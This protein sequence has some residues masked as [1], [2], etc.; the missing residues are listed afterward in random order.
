[1]QH[2]IKLEN[3]TKVHFIGVGGISMNGLAQILARDGYVVSGSDKQASEVTRILQK[4][5]IDIKVP[6]AA[7]NI[8]P[9]YD[10][11]VFTDAIQPDNPEYA[12]AVELGLPMMGRASLLKIIT[13]GY[14]RTVC[15]AGSHGK[16]TTTALL[17]SVAQAAGLDP[18]VHVGGHVAGALNNR[19]GESPFFLLEACEYKNNFLQWHPYIGVILNIDADHNDF[20]GGGIDGLIDSFAQFARNIHPEGALII[21]AQTQGFDRI[22]AGL[23]CRVISFGLYENPTGVHLYPRDVSFSDGGQPYFSAVK[24]DEV[25]ASVDLALVGEHNIANALACFAVAEALALAPQAVKRGLEAAPGVK[26]RYEYK[27]EFNSVPII[28]DYA[29]HPTEVRACLAASRKKH[30]GRIVCVFQPH[31]YSRTRDLMEEFANSFGD[32][33]KVLLLPIYAA[34]EVHD[35]TVS[36]EQLCDLMRRRNCDVECF[37]DFYTAEQWL[38]LHLV[39]GDL[40]LTVGAGNVHL[41]AETLL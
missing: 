5:G 12:R 36:S 18:T 15:V 27:G 41:I 35:P 2:K 19:V 26:R 25:L 31:L 17:A 6:N 34:R 40:L 14:E 16:T 21:N 20:Y 22:V 28:D 11:I 3:V 29:H 7:D 4:A 9:E 23:A 39:A 32:A 33:D 37:D 10:L 38:R 30:S 24:G 1:M 13:Q 8:S